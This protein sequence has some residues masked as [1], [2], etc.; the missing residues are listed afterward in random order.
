MSNT[1][2]KYCEGEK[3]FCGKLSVKKISEVILDDENQERHPYTQYVC[4]SCFD[5]ALRPYLIKESKI[6]RI[7]KHFIR[8]K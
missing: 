8:W 4:Q 5:K 3:C 7:L 2:S 1:I 6:L